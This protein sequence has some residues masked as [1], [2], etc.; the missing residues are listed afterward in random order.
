V[1]D[2]DRL[3]AS[4]FAAGGGDYFDIWVIDDRLV[5]V[6]GVRRR[7]IVNGFIEIGDADGI[8]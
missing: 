2:E 7:G 3:G 1:S 4:A 5:Y 6:V 8:S